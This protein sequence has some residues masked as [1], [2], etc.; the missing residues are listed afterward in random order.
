MVL[1]KKKS[2]SSDM[3]DLTVA[4]AIGGVAA[5]VAGSS[6]LPYGLGNATGAMIGVGLLS[7]ASKMPTKKYNGW[8]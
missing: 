1:M 7:K 3:I 6:G 8:L 5:G 2:L 4:G